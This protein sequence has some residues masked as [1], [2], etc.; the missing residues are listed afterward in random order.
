MKLLSSILRKL[1]IAIGSLFVLLVCL[2]LALQTSFA[3][4][5][6][7]AYM[8]R[9]VDANYNV[10]IKIGSL[11]YRFSPP[12]FLRLQDVKVYGG[13]SGT[14]LF[15]D[16]GIIDAEIPY[17]S[18]FGN[19]FVIQKLG[20]DKPS[21]QPENLPRIKSKSDEKSSKTFEIRQLTLTAGN[22]RY[23]QFSIEQ[24]TMNARI[25]PDGIELKNLVAKL[26]NLEIH[27]DGKMDNL[28]DPRYI[29]NY[30]VKGNADS[31]SG[32]FPQ[33][34]SLAG[35]ISTKGNIEGAIGYY[36]I[37]GTFNS[38][39]LSVYEEKPIPVVA[40][41]KI[42]SRNSSS[43]YQ[44]H[45]Q[46]SSLPVSILQKVTSEIPPIASEGTGEISYS[47]PADP[48]QGSG[49]Y[50]VQFSPAGLKGIPLY[51]TLNGSLGNGALQILKGDFGW[52]R[53][54]AHIGGSLSS[55]QMSVNVVAVI[56]DL[57]AFASFAPELRKVPGVYRMDSTLRGSYD[58][59]LI[60]WKVN[61][62]GSDLKLVSSG[63]Y[64]TGSR[65]VQTNAS[66]EVNGAV[67]NRLYPSDLSGKFLFSGTASGP[68][69]SLQFDA[70]IEGSSIQVK[71]AAVGDAVVHL[72]SD[73][74][75]VQAAVE[76][77]DLSSTVQGSYTLAAHR[78]QMLAHFEDLTSEQIKTLLPQAAEGIS[79]KVT[80][81]LEASGDARRWRNSTANLS[82]EEANFV[83]GDIQVGLEKGSLVRLQ[84][85][86]ASVDLTARTM[87]GRMHVQGTLPLAS[88]KSLHLH[89][90]GNSSLRAL[91]LFT[92]KVDGDGLVQIDL[93]IDGTFAQP[94]IGG[95]VSSEKFSL[96]IPSFG[97]QITEGK[98][99]ADIADSRI[100][101]KS[102]VLMN[103]AP[104]QIEGTLP[105]MPTQ[106]MNVRVTG[107]ADLKLLALVTQQVQGEGP[108]SV[109]ITVLGTPREPQYSGKATAS[110]FAITAQ[111]F[112]LAD[113]N[114]SAEFTGQE[115]RVNVTGV[116]NGSKLALNGALS[117]LEGPGSLHMRLD[118]FPVST[119]KPGTEL[120]GAVSV[121]VDATGTGLKLNAWNGLVTVHPQEMKIRGMQVESPS[122]IQVKVGQG[123]V[124]L[125]PFRVKAGDLLDMAAEAKLNLEKGEIQGKVDT[126]AELAILTGLVQ[127]VQAS[128][129]LTAK[130]SVTGKWTSPQ[131]AGEI[132]I[133]DGV[134]RQAESPVL[135]EQ[136]ELIAPV[137]QDK[138][139]IQTLT[140][141]M[142]GG[143]IQGGGSIALRNWAPGEVNLWVKAERVGLRY[144]EDL[145]SQVSAD[146]KFSGG[147]NE[148]LL[149]GKV[150]IIRS[151]YR[152]DF[153]P[154]QRLVHSL[155][156]EKA[157]LSLQSPS[158]SRFKLELEV[159]T[160][161]D[162]QVRNNLGK[163]QAG[164]NLRVTGTIADPRI[165]GR[166][167]IREGGQILF[168]GNEFEV[169]RG[170]IDFYGK[171]KIDPVFDV[172][173]FTTVQDIDT[174]QDYEITYPLSGPSSELDDRD[175]TSFP[176]LS[177]NQIHFLLLTGRA[178]ADLTSASE[179]FF[180][181][182]LA[183]Y[184]SGQ[185]FSDMQK[186]VA[187]TFGLQR[188]ELQPEAVSSETNPGAKMVL[189]KDFTSSL[190][191]VYSVSL[192]ESREQTWVA[193]YR[194]RRNLTFR[195]VDQDDGTYTTNVR[196]LVRFGS[197]VSSRSLRPS[198]KAS[199]TR[200]GA[201]EIVNESVL[202]DSEIKKSIGKEEGDR[203]DFW[204]MQDALDSIEKDLQKRGYLFATTEMEETT[205]DNRIVNLRIHVAGGERREMAFQ[206]MEVTG[207][208][209][210][211]YQQYW[212]E[213]FSE[214]AVM[215]LIREDI[216]S[217]L[218][219]KGYH[220]AEVSKHLQDKSGVRVC[221]FEI[222][223]GINYKDT[224]LLF[225][226]ARLYP[227]KELGEDLRKLYTSREEMNSDA[228]HRFTSIQRK[229]TALYTQNGFLDAKVESGSVGFDEGGVQKQILITEGSPSRISD[230]FI[231][232]GVE[233]PDDL[234]SK[235]KMWTGSVYDQRA[236]A[237]DE[238]AIREYYDERGY[239]K[240][241]LETETHRE[242]ETG[243][244]ILQY[245]VRTGGVA[246]VHAIQIT[247]NHRT[248][249]RLLEKRIGLKEG[250]VLN[251]E[252]IAN[253]QRGLTDLHI[254]H[255]VNVRVEETD[256]QDQY[257]VV[258]EVIEMKHYEL[259]YG[260]RYDTEKGIGGEIQLADLS[261][262]G[263]GN[264]LSFYTRVSSDNQLFRTVF[265]SPIIS[266]I[267][268]K[269]L[270]SAS[271]ENGEL[272]LRETDQSSLAEG[273]RY[274]FN[275]DRT[276]QLT[277]GFRL[278]GSYEFERLRTR[279]I[280]SPELPFDSFKIST[281]G[282]T[283]FTDTRDQPLNA[284]R[285]RFLSFDFRIA[286]SF[287]PTD[288]TF[289][290]GYAQYFEFVPVKKLTWASG[291]RV[292]VAS[293]LGLRLLTERF[294]AGGSFTIRG[295]EKDQVGPKDLRGNP[296]GGEAVFII[297]QELRFPVYKWI[298]GAVFYDAGNVYADIGDFNPL[299]LRH[300]VGVGLRVNS[301][302]G[303][304][305]IDLGFNLG[306]R[307]DEPQTVLHF[308][309]GQAF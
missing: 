181:Q 219:M 170:I 196:H 205:G 25:Q 218:W 88:G 21:L 270:V 166:L 277:R 68:I 258:A 1:L 238:L 252:K 151:T 136:I 185:I 79:G 101:L 206:G 78:Y 246:R 124:E 167:Q 284:T 67:I 281:L 178:N 304:A 82:I 24:I 102:T 294:L 113:G 58:D 59:L 209:K 253:A 103:E 175:P 98:L 90:G 4:R 217:K 74:R 220:K 33:I 57:G 274:E 262:F 125:L 180:K 61:G 244:L 40:E 171:R 49:T 77:P 299:R 39:N 182:Q 173:L 111:Q 92:N 41:Y 145:R 195:F 298:G 184:V 162:F 34:P 6:V 10:K 188:V 11:N 18:F 247:G 126:V 76:L 211:R 131:Y 148:Y 233:F 226:G 283:I 89:A 80:G 261:L 144:P 197:G 237:E 65:K 81:T 169:R 31:L 279:P 22:L 243:N 302:F 135:L 45:L 190:S 174:R 163:L 28:S 208:E 301:P 110:N 227:A 64:S 15:L 130:M 71:E 115:L 239:R 69:K 285:G 23:L 303:V 235:L 83:K 210:E 159:R 231:T 273:Q 307:A 228:L 255:Q 146:L 35:E 54:S 164:A 176:P 186:Q 224:T 143:T 201:V 63:S 26:E 193:S 271:Y 149:S 153:D 289:V 221:V 213:G 156:S 309:L 168:Q 8:E 200:I 56:A 257:D 73:G 137:G 100:S 133:Q 9:Y 95:T 203:Y 161:E 198:T 127:D 116:L 42:D 85:Q 37:E 204:Q 112:T 183:S 290:K 141:R 263:T 282:A 55:S 207:K 287:L 260:F 66:G 152:E 230:V 194:V 16:A 232:H 229:V 134:F 154:Q 240:F 248:S 292:G 266:G 265:H 139:T 121:A 129:K 147:L 225:E 48:W 132:R 177:S 308:G 286:P 293:D 214:Q 91:S 215:E 84:N 87:D 278:I 288:A 254:F 249:R 75:V 291:V 138:I 123:M 117:M 268:W 216:L 52:G 295:F 105:L 93:S 3:K 264:G 99:Q 155:L 297:N 142:G 241:E 12:F 242:Q 202:T 128:G 119:L 17:A 118:S 13:Q 29:I 120:S 5:H 36:R 150:Q 53:S 160:L 30:E 60:S 296:L 259:T 7:A 192:T 97:V 70:T 179:Q 14:G 43:P 47:G 72:N 212:R 199:R 234:K 140:G 122:P 189:G 62:S 267:K 157:E 86:I 191:L 50:Q 94:R 275:V 106:P 280:F 305:R 32:L 300:S 108:V 187:R 165:S 251:Q 256:V 2:F 109:D 46:F 236:L 38:G 222:K 223:P 306:R 44:V 272:I 245:N 269:T 51:G 250:E 96:A 276:Y 158:A 20:L 172:E 19:S 107:Q 27:G 104:F 114:G